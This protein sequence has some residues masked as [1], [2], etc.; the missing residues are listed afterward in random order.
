M[1]APTG[2]P[3]DHAAFE[4]LVL[5]LMSPDNATRA[6]GEAR[7]AEAKRAPDAVV[8]GLLAVLTASASEDARAYCAVLL[9]KV[10]VGMGRE[11]GRC[12][13]SVG[14]A[15]APRRPRRLPPSPPLA[16]TPAPPPR[17]EATL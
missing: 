8:R 9:R 2:V 12:D 14:R 7:F 11:G 15:H 16:R 5:V 4:Q 10:C 1:A 13:V 17:A 6:A 3:P